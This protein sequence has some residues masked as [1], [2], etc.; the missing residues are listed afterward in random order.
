[1][2]RP[3][4]LTQTEL[5]T[6]RTAAELLPWVWSAIQRFNTKELKPEYLK[7]SDL[8]D[9]LRDELLPIALFADRYFG[10]SADVTIRYVYGDQPHDAVV[11]DR[12]EQPGPVKFI[13]ATLADHNYDMSLRLELLARDGSVPLFGPVVVKG[14][15][16][17][18]TEL[19]AEAEAVDHEDVISNHLTRVQAAV[20][21]KAKK[22]YPDGTALVVRVADAEGFR[23]EEDREDLADFVQQRVL[24]LLRNREFCVLAIVGSTGLYQ[25]YN[26]Q[27]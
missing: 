25:A 26:L 1:V 16:R 27:S 12:R 7:G 20:E 19:R 9:A 24:P 18:R 23:L 11:E 3:L 17:H 8:S 2:N 10:K 22:K 4:P 21:K 14:S 5:E 13:E 15:R 6:P